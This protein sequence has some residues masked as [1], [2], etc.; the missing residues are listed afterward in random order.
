MY[1]AVT[2]AGLCLKYRLRA[3]AT[4]DPLLHVTLNK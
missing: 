4:A 2:V 3:S 1:H